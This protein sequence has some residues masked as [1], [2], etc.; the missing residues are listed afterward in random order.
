[1]P[2]TESSSQE[3]GVPRNHPGSTRQG[4]RGQTANAIDENLVQAQEA[5]RILDR[6]AGFTLTP[7]IWNFVAPGLSAGRVQSVA[8]A[9]VV[10]RER[11]RLKFKSADYWD[12]VANVTAVG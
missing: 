6:L 1:G 3:G 8:L 11:A 4:I 9:M 7:V 12:V 2:G 10:E 5:R